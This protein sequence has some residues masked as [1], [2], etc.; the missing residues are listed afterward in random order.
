MEDNY[1]FKTQYK[2]SIAQSC[3][4]IDE[5]VSKCRATVREACCAMERVYARERSRANG[6]C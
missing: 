1:A 6:V 2:L 5:N 4:P 3:P